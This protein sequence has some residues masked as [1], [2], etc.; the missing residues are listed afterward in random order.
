M[1]K[2]QQQAHIMSQSMKMSA[3]AMPA[4]ALDIAG[5]EVD[6]TSWLFE[7]DK[8]DF[9]SVAKDTHSLPSEAAG[10]ASP[11]FITSLGTNYLYY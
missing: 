8:L 10:N 6:L 3:A 5:A 1:I 11:P 9:C 2:E 7:D 4:A